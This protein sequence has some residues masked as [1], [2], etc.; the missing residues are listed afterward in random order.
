MKRRIDFLEKQYSV[1]VFGHAGG[2]YLQVA[3]GQAQPVALT[4]KTMHH[5]IIQLGDQRMDIQLA[6]KGETAYIRAIDRTFTLRV[7]DPVEQAAQEAGGG[8]NT[9]RAPMPGTVVEVQVAAGEMVSKGQPMITIESMKI[10]MVI[11]A[12]RDGEVSEI[13]FEPGHTFD[14][15]ATLVTLKEIEEA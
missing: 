13:H 6:V 1:T 4:M 9:A 8:S 3:D 14:K 5:G 15:N 11:T 7:V 10:L 2:H 12:T